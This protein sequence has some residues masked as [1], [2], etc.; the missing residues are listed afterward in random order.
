V[1]KRNIWSRCKKYLERKEILLIIGARQTGKTTL[2]RA[3]ASHLEQEGGKVFFLTL[4]SPLL[5]AALNENPENIFKYIPRSEQ[6]KYLLLD[7]V[8]YLQNP[9]KFLKYI[10]D[11]YSDTIKLV[12]SGSS[13]FYIDRSFKDSLAGRKRIIELFPFSFSE[14]LR[15]KAE[16]EL[17]KTIQEESWCITFKKRHLLIPE[18]EKLGAYLQ[19]YIVY[20]GY[21][22]VVTE[23]D[24]EEKRFILKDI[25]E[26]FLKKDI[27]E[28]GVTEEYKFYQLLK[29]IASS[30]GSLVNSSEIANTIS[31]SA[32]TVRE[33]IHVLR[34]SFI[35]SV[36][37]PFHSNV[38]KELT[39]MPKIYMLDSGLRNVVL[40]DFRALEDR[41]DKGELLE[42]MVFIALRTFGFDNI[43]FWR[44]QDKKEVDFIVDTGHALE[45]KWQPSAF[46]PKKYEKFTSAYPDI[47]LNPVFY[48]DEHQLDLLDLLH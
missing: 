12:V 19:E 41:Q 7:E 38:R 40:N 27:R 2:L 5:L 28:A 43:N 17:S 26:S 39:K 4:E 42:N 8:Q 9:S 36:I 46:R 29:I 6:Q 3:I 34:K 21:P 20:G 35:T 11:I 31:L 33:Y 1:V 23:P 24:G 32:D 30:A 15:A 18:R 37:P 44:T 16:L 14:F 25:H 10:Y 22:G 47:P 13:A 45:V 48:Y